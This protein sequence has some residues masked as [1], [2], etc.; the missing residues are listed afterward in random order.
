MTHLI[1]AGSLCFQL[2]GVPMTRGTETS[3]GASAAKALATLKANCFECHNPEKSK[4]DLVLTSRETILKGGDSGPALVSGKA[5]ES[6]IV[7]VL[8]P[9]ADPHMPP[10]KQLSDE[11]ISEIKQW[12]DAGAVWDAKALEIK[13]PLLAN[14]ALGALP[15]SY[16]PVFAIALSPDEKRLAVGRGNQIFIHDTSTNSFPLAQLLEGH[17]DAVQSLA[18]SRDGKWLASGGF[19]RASVWD[20]GQGGKPFKFV[21]QNL[22]G[23]VTAL[24]FSSDGQTLIVADGQ[25]A[26]SGFVH[27]VPIH[28][29]S[30]HQSIK[31]QAHA[32]TIFDL[33]VSPDGSKLATAGADR[34]ARV[35]GLKEQKLL[36]TLEGHSDYVS[37]VAFRKDKSQLAS[38]SADKEIKVW[39]LKTKELL[40]NN[41]YDKEY[42]F[43]FP[44]HSRAVT[45]LAWLE[46]GETIVSVSEDGYARWCTELKKHKQRRLASAGE[47]LYCV[48][49]TK[50]GSAIYAGS[51]S[52]VVHIWG[53]DGKIKAKLEPPSAAKPETAGK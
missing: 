6:L 1:A 32:D 49:A 46:K 13:S 34:L 35:W 7:E 19:R 39:D 2:A 21:T 41:R 47:I 40:K 50:D 33:D 3:T 16:R 5:L 11:Q 23:R 18:W 9:D 48:A 42:T 31:W 44:K 29:K 17:K 37:A 20:A 8:A 28:G 38:A 45:G 26:K 52:G 30:S 22:V 51:E 15:G 36:A 10:K 4:A 27:L 25:P 43:T 12:I 24:A 14:A 53:A